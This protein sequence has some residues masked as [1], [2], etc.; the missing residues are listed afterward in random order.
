M[1]ALL[2]KRFPVV[3]AW[4]RGEV[5]S[6]GSRWI[7]RGEAPGKCPPATVRRTRRYPSPVGDRPADQRRVGPG[8]AGRPG[9]RSDREQGPSHRPSDP[10]SGDA[11]LASGMNVATFAVATNEFRGNGKE[12]AEYHTVVT[13]TA[14][15]RSAASTSA[16]ASRSPSRAG[17]RPGSGTTTA[18]R[19]TGRP[20][21]S[22]PRRDALGPPQARL[23]GRVR[24][25]S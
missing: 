14:S 7:R 18:A 17:S 8:P 5:R 2:R 16:R 11:I 24:R 3:T 25:E 20:R 12:H 21:S 4:R 1:A 10:R 13:G 15:P 23:R 22:P 9:R 19:A 6:G